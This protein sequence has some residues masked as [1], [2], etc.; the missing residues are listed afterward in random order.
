MAPTLHPMSTEQLL[1]DATEEFDKAVQE[2]DY[3]RA[4]QLAVS[5]ILTSVSQP[6]TQP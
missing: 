6:R 4:Q 1:I 5:L 3:V 2:K